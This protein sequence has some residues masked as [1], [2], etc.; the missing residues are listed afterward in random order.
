MRSATCIAARYSRPGCSGVCNTRIGSSTL[1]GPEHP[2]V[3]S[4]ASTTVGRTRRTNRW[5]IG[6]DRK[7]SNHR[8]MTTKLRTTLETIGLDWLLDRVGQ[9]LSRRRRVR[10]SPRQLT[11]PSR[12]TSRKS[13]RPV[14]PVAPG[15]DP[16]RSP[17]ERAPISLRQV[18]S[19]LQ[20]GAKDH[21]LTDEVREV[22]ELIRP[23][24]QADDG[25]VELVDITP[26]GVV[27]VR[28]HGACVGCP[29]SAIT[30]QTG[31]ERNLR[32]RIPQITGVIAVD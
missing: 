7:R 4:A 25:D 30:L 13:T 23:A 16:E 9:V 5:G 12:S 2:P 26:E 10:A 8:S 19:K 31:I 21:E 3:K 6:K 29:S 20:S 27:R 28:F 18:S 24:V 1:E 11:M 14:P 22:L 32:L 15:V 17:T